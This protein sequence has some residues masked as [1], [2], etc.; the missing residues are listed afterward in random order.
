MAEL[1]LKKNLLF[2]TCLMLKNRCT[3]FAFLIFI[4]VVPNY[5]FIV[6]NFQ[7]LYMARAPRIFC[8]I[9]TTEN[10]LHDHAQTVYE[11]WAYKCDDHV[12]ISMINK[13]QT[14][15]IKNGYK[16]FFKINF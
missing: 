8:M 7:K 6:I 4:S 16:F 1:F 2:F 14:S 10:H 9:L 11:T 15:Q 5:F 13:N 3:L 12:F